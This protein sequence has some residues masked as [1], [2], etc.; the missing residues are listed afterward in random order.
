MPASRYRFRL[1]GP[2]RVGAVA[3]RGF[4]GRRKRCFPEPVGQFAIVMNAK[5]ANVRTKTATAVSIGPLTVA[6]VQPDASYNWTFGRSIPDVP[7]AHEA[8]ASLEEFLASPDGVFP[9]RRRRR[10]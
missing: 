3:L 10:R 2:D 9:R 8:L 7:L 1:W 4:A 5:A 6:S